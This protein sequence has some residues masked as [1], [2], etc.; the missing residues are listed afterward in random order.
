MKKMYYASKCFSW[1]A[2]KTNIKPR[3]VDEKSNIRSNR[4]RR[5][6]L[7]TPLTEYVTVSLNFGNRW[8]WNWNY[9]RACCL[10]IWHFLQDEYI[11]VSNFYFNVW[12]QKSVVYSSSRQVWVEVTNV[13]NSIFG[14]VSIPIQDELI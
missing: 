13:R 7:A 3:A 11:S 14:P 12:V 8:Y 1:K 9:G 10:K 5:L 4:N 6:H 2:N